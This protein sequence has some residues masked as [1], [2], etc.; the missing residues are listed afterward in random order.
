MSKVHTLASIMHDLAV[1]RSRRC[2]GV[3]DF[4]LVIVLCLSGWV[5]NEWCWLRQEQQAVAILHRDYDA[6]AMDGSVSS[7]MPDWRPGIDLGE[8]QRGR[9]YSPVSSVFFSHRGT[10]IDRRAWEQ[11]ARFRYLED[12]TFQDCRLA[13]ATKFRFAQSWL[14]EEVVAAWHARHNRHAAQHIGI[15]PSSRPVVE[16]NWS[17]G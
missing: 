16:W 7:T 9:L 5:A 2:L 4:G 1:H 10:V 15:E 17:E 14:S 13:S 6:L 12:I 3:I 11:I 8:L